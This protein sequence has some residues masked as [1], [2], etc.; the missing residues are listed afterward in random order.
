MTSIVYSDC[1]ICHLKQE[2][3]E[4]DAGERIT[5]KCPRCGKFT[6]TATAARQAEGKSLSTKLSCWIRGRTEGGGEV[7]EI[8]THNLP[9]ILKDLPNYLVSDKKLLLLRAIERR[10][11]F[12]GA[13]VTLKPSL[14]HPV[15]WAET[16]REFR[17][18]VDALVDRGLLRMEQGTATDM[19]SNVLGVEIAAD[20]WDFLEEHQRKSVL[21][22]QAFV[23]MSFAEELRPTWDN[24]I[25]PAIER[26]GFLA[27]RV[28][29][30]PHA[31]RI[32]LKIITEI[33]NSRF[34]VADVTQQRPGVYFEAGF[35]IGMGLPVIWCVRQ[36]D[37]ENVHFDTRQY[38][39]LVW[40]DENE[41][42]DRLYTFIV[43]IV[44]KGSRKAA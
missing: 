37:L 21:S 4:T 17:Y 43:A 33:K 2:V 25:R 39:H 30:A 18:L 16:E 28:D 14:D 5:V 41:L 20:G 32:D 13:P 1:P 19:N 8:N 36:D 44:G 24:G 27:Y 7:S 9:A 42:A 22:E 34:V 10:T 29:S 40:R 15:A 23:A 38:N 12:P 26:A 6:I 3:V 11:K 35:A 31:E